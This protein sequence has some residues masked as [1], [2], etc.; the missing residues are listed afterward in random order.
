MT[1]SD[2]FSRVSQII[3]DE[4]GCEISEVHLKASAD[5]IDGWDSLAHARLILKIEDVFNLRLPGD[6]LFELDNVGDLVALVSEAH[7]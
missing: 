6:R 4:L 2:V 5:D 3:S 7:V 1:H